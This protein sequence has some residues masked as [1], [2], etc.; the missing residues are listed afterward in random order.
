MTLVIV[1]KHWTIL[2]SQI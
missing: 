1:R 2:Y